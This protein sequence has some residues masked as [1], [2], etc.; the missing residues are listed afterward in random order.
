M[1]KELIKTKVMKINEIINELQKYAELEL[2][3]SM[4]YFNNEK[5]KVY[6]L[7]AYT[8]RRLII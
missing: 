3:E 1:D 5:M 7:K 6:E 2:E 8:P 4:M